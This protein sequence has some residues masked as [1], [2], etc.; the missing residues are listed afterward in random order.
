M[1][2]NAGNGDPSQEG[3]RNRPF[4]SPLLTEFEARRTERGVRR[5]WRCARVP[6]ICAALLCLV[7][8]FVWHR[9]I[10]YVEEGALRRDGWRCLSEIA[11]SP[12]SRK[13]RT[14]R[15]EDEARLN[16][17]FRA[18]ERLSSPLPELPAASFPSEIGPD[19]LPA[20]SEGF[21]SDEAHEL[22]SNAVFACETAGVEED[23]NARLFAMFH[24]DAPLPESIRALRVAAL[25]FFRRALDALDAGDA[26]AAWIDASLLAKTGR[27]MRSKG[28]T[29]AVCEAAVV[30]QMQNLLYARL[31]AREDLSDDERARIER[32]WNLALHE[33]S[34][35][36][37][38]AVH[39]ELELLLTACEQ[40]VRFRA[41]RIVRTDR[42]YS[43]N[44]PLPS[45]EILYDSSAF[46][47]EPREL[48][49]FQA[50]IQY[51]RTREHANMCRNLVY[52]RDWVMKRGMRPEAGFRMWDKPVP[53]MDLPSDSPLFVCYAVMRRRAL[54][55]RERLFR[56]EFRVRDERC[57]RPHCWCMDGVPCPYAEWRD[58]HE[59][60]SLAP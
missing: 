31:R 32:E 15:E 16:A 54:A 33:T 29:N 2:T 12:D 34:A 45:V 3:K 26:A 52:A 43:P 42:P 58:G 47:S 28:M 30:A 39:E 40:A 38:S 50:L 19:D 13:R 4:R 9:I 6:L 8:A 7:A 46:P 17:L 22:C 44:R 18:L 55:V 1:K 56:P 21:S 14:R 48:N 37:F 53:N 41:P 36:F 49:A 11:P 35:C 60:D 51:P 57:W 59:R 24:A 25:C 23:A 27:L 5:F 10:D 20:L